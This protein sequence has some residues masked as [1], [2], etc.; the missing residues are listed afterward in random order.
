[1][2]FQGVSTSLKSVEQRREVPFFQLRTVILPKKFEES[3]QD[4]E[5]AFDREGEKLERNILIIS[6]S[7]L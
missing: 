2:E 1:M 6:S 4:T 3:I 7:S 5:V